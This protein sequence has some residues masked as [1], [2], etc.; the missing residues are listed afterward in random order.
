MGTRVSTHGFTFKAGPSAVRWAQIR[1]LVSSGESRRAKA[2]SSWARMHRAA[3]GFTLQ[4]GRSAVRWAQI[5]RL[6]SSG[7]SRRAKAL[8]SWARMHRVQY[9]SAGPRAAK[10]LGELMEG[11]IRDAAALNV[12]FN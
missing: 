4:A 7:G 8:S 9:L 2:F 1:R 12:V 3:Q 10:Q 5:R 6:V 11:D